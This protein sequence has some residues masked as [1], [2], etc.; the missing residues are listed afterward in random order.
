MRCADHV[1]DMGPG[2]GV[3]GGADRGRRAPPDE[4]M[5]NPTSLT[6]QYLSGRAQMP[7][8]RG[9][10]ARRPGRSCCGIKGA[11]EQQPAR[12]RR[13]AS[14]WACSPASPGV[15]GSGKST[16]INDTLYAAGRDS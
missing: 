16:L 10:R 7:Y 9:A 4:V 15:S 2:A 5:A 3:H 11:R 14:R 1:I 13:G 6:G 12:R 8:P